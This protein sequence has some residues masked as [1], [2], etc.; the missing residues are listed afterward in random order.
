M[1]NVGIDP[2][3]LNLDNKLKLHGLVTLHRGKVLWHATDLKLD[4]S[5]SRSE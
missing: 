3:I 5:H 2:R 4:E 1:R